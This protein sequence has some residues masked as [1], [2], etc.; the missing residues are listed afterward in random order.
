MVVEAEGV[1]SGGNAIGRINPRTASSGAGPWP[2]LWPGLYLVALF[3]PAGALRAL[4]GFTKS[5]KVN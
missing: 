2:G 3:I 4:E 5:T 1:V